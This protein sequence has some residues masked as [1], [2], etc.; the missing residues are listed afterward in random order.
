M[1]LL[2]LLGLVL[3]N[4]VLALS[5]TAL[6]SA[7]KS[8]LKHWA[9]QRRSGAA[10]AL[11]LAAEP[12]R[13]LSTVQVGITLV[14]PLSGAIGG[15]TVAQSLEAQLAGV[16]WIGAR[17]DELAI[18]IVVAVL[19]RGGLGQVLGIVRA[20]ALLDDAWR[21]KAVDLATDLV[22]PIFVPSSLTMIELLE[23]FTKHRQHLT[24]VLDEYGELQ[25]LV[26]MND[27]LEALVG[28]V[29]TADDRAEPDIVQRDDGS[30]LVDGDVVPE[31]FRAVVHLVE[32]LPHEETG[33]YH[34]LGGLAMMQL[35]R[36]PQVGDRFECRGFR[37]EILDM[38]RNRVDKLLA[39]RIRHD[40]AAAGRGERESR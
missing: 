38:D 6:V 37:F 30:W 29:A 23:A 21:D 8:R 26:T 17:A 31:R 35:A 5:E 10:A 11:A 25:G 3:L 12:S 19:C 4:G 40:P 2:I 7:R 39:T 28:E 9:D 1:E 15:A 27:V 13:F 20:K 32:R 16:P 22:K 34:T 24:L 18:A 14:G 33:S 36:I